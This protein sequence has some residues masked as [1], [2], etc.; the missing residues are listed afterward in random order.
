MARSNAASSGCFNVEDDRFLAAIQP[1]EIGALPVRHRIVAAREI[2]RRS[3]DLDHSRACVG[4]TRSAERRRDR[5]FERDDENA[6]EGAAAHRWGL[7]SRDM[8]LDFNFHE[9]PKP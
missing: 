6:L 4:E 2:S 3:F 7:G 5:L 9:N 1:D 8:P